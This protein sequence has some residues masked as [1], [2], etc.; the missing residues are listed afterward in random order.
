MQNIDDQSAGTFRRADD[1][2]IG[3]CD[4]QLCPSIEIESELTKIVGFYNDRIKEGYHPFEE[5]VM[6]HYFFEMIHPFSD[7]NGRVGREIFNFMLSKDRYPKLLFLGEARDKF[8]QALKLGNDEKYIEMNHYFAEIIVSQ[9]LEILRSRIK[10]YI[11]KPEKTGQLTLQS[12]IS[13]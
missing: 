7:G 1:R 11:E 13:I 12:F 8:V 6:F 4:L 9:R 3:G 10:T 2:G 5:A